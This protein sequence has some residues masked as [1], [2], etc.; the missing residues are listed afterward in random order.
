MQALQVIIPVYGSLL[1]SKVSETKFK[2][3]IT[4]DGRETMGMASLISYDHQVQDASTIKFDNQ[5]QF[6]RHH[7]R[8]VAHESILATKVSKAPKDGHI[9]Y[10]LFL[11]LVDLESPLKGDEDDCVLFSNHDF[12]FL[13]GGEIHQWIPC[14][15]HVI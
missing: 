13:K 7:K 4:N 14:K 5:E 6:G 3:V 10:T 1:N 9:R 15:F 2:L 11:L 8:W 12:N